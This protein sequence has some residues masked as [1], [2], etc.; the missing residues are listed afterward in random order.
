[1]DLLCNPKMEFRPGIE[2]GLA[3]RVA[4]PDSLTGL[5]ALCLALYD[6]FDVLLVTACYPPATLVV[7]LRCAFCD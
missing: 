5:P 6:E 1:M 7:H 2:M 4:F 3:C